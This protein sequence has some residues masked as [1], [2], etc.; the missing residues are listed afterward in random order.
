MS[1]SSSRGR[2]EYLYSSAKEEWATP[3]QF[4]DMLDAEFHFTLDPCATAEN[5]KVEQFFTR[6][7]DGLK[8]SWSGS[9]FMNPPY[10]RDIRKW[11][12]KAYMESRRGSVVVCL[13]PARTDTRYWHEFVMHADDIRFVRGRLRFEGGAH[14][15]PF[16][17]VVVIFRPGRNGPPRVTSMRDRKRHQQER[18]SW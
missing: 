4:F 18:P 17:S 15:A 14:S 5:A 2:L 8:Q 11:M 9:V 7:S 12:A 6:E 10:G 1:A 16:P 13:I 3:R